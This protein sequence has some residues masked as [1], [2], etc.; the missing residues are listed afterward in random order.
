MVHFGCKESNQDEE[1]EVDYDDDD[2]DSD[3]DEDEDVEDEDEDVF[4]GMSQAGTNTIK[5][6]SESDCSVM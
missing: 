3:D 2:D 6:F 4:E 1:E 5:L